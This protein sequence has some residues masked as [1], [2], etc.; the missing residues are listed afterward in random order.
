MVC[1][2]IAWFLWQINVVTGIESVCH[3]TSSLSLSGQL[4][5]SLIF[6][7][8]LFIKIQMKSKHLLTLWAREIEHGRAWQ[9]KV[10]SFLE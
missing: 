6:R 10:S 4:F 8:T 7:Q 3:H 5:Y 2:I 9:R 1:T